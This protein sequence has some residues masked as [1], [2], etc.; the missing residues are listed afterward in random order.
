ML[1]WKSAAC[2]V[3]GGTD[4]SARWGKGPPEKKKL[5]WNRFFVSYWLI[6]FRPA[7][8]LSTRAL[9]RKRVY[10]LAIY[11]FFFLL[12]IAL[13]V[14]S[15]LGRIPDEARW[16]VQKDD[17]EG[18]ASKLLWPWGFVHDESDWDPKRILSLLRKKSNQRESVLRA[19]VTST[20]CDVWD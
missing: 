18:A 16:P 19:T 12:V 11:L 5:T 9:L 1:F 2:D 15:K 14:W 3:T 7:K 8:T 6:D 4:N 20:V 10:L 17:R 13:S